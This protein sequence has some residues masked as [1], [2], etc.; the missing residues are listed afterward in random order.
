MPHLRT[1]CNALLLPALSLLL[2]VAC[3]D[4]AGTDPDD[5]A[6]NFG[7]I[8]NILFWSVPEKVAGFRNMPSLTPT[9]SIAAGANPYPLPRKE[10][11]LSG[12]TFVFDDTELSIDDYIRRYNVAGLLVIKDGFVVYERYELGNTA[13]SRWMSWS[14]AKSVTSLLVGAAIQDGYIK[15]VDE[16][17]S[18][19]LPRL[20]DS[21]YDDLSIRAL[22]QMASGVAWNEDYADPQSDI[23]T[24][25]WDTLSV[26]E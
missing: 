25:K 22:L 18:D 19:Y 10:S 20:K 4:A 16:K 9:R 6:A 17:V 13:D 21:S 8:D 1:T 14:I 26:Y 12:F 7:T 23:N 24:I 11:D 15:S 5:D 3:G 2:A